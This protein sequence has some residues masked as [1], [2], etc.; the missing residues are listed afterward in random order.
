MGGKKGTRVGSSNPEWAG[1]AAPSSLTATAF[2]YSEIRLSWQDNSNYEDGFEI[3]RSLDGTNWGTEPITTTNANTASYSDTDISQSTAYYYR[4]R[5]MNLIGDRSEWSNTANATTPSILPLLR[6]AQ[7]AAGSY[8]TLALTT[9]GRAWAWG[10]N[11]V[12]QLGLGDTIVTSYG[13]ISSNR[14][15]PSLI[16]SD[17]GWVVFEDISGLSAGV[18][19]G[20]ALKTDGTLWSWGANGAGQLGL[21]DTFSSDAP[22]QIGLYSSDRFLVQADS[23]WMSVPM[24]GSSYHITALKTNNTLWAWGDNGYGQL[25]MGD[26]GDG[27]LGSPNTNRITPT[28]IGTESDWLSVAVGGFNTS[29]IKTNNT[30]W[31]W[32]DNTFGQLG[33]GTY[34]TR[35]T[36]RQ[37][38][39]TSD[40]STAA[41]GSNIYGAHSIGLKTNGTLWAWGN[42]GYGQLG[43]GTTDNGTTPRSIGTNSDWSQIVAGVS[44]TLA[45]KT[46][47]TLW[48]WG[49]NG[50][51]QL[52]DGTYDTRTAPRQIGA[53][54]DWAAVA[55]GGYVSQ[56]HTIGLK[57][58][59]TIWVWGNNEFGQ[60]GMGD[61]IN[62]N[63]PCPLGSPTPPSSLIS[64]AI[65]LSQIAINWTDNSNNETGF[66]IERGITNTD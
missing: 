6:W 17:I 16:E 57:T 45:L 24:A 13:Y 4:I 3:W 49:D 38:G 12:G 28:Q 23:D 15:T 54:S 40:W 46:N 11:I 60:L 10:S 47:N 50:Y 27:L 58:N 52:G 65:G 34:D 29:G 64:T 33:D 22:T 8:Y 53:E 55:T 18:S 26:I 35:T 5:A 44:Y 59:G 21:G 32:G 20:I 42:N 51:G 41:V 63:T 39:T 31:A 19:F 56:Y 48:A 62:R 66:I 61:T 25:G 14:T 36:P 37:I 7:V 30:L 1:I 43:D 2:S 9:D